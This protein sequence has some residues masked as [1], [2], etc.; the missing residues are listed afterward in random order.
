M[1]RFAL[2][3]LAGL[4]TGPAA[5]PFGLSMTLP[6][7]LTLLATLMGSYASQL[8]AIFGVDRIRI[9][10][11]A[12]R[13]RRDADTSHVPKDRLSTKSGR[14]ARRILDR[15]GAPG[16][17]MVGPVLFGNWGSAALGAALGVPRGRLL[18]WLMAGS[19]MWCSLTLLAAATTI[20]VFD[21]G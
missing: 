12:W 18:P 4:V 7:P 17:G 5:I 20:D 6:G 3:M 21:L 14:R 15:F 19:A 8:C 13:K 10:W 2:V 11:R 16:L 1:K 9:I